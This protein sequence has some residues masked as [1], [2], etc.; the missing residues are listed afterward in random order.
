[1]EFCG[2][3]SVAD[4]IRTTETPLEEHIISYVCSETLKVSHPPM[5]V[6]PASVACRHSLD[7]TGRIRVKFESKL[8]G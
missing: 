4:I 5:D 2:G 7:G 3:G 1:M 8:L 6:A